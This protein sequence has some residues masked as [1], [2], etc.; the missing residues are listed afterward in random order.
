[1]LALK[2]K[3]KKALSIYTHKNYKI[4]FLYFYLLQ[5]SGLPDNKA[6]SVKLGGISELKKYMKR[7]MPFVQATRENVER[8]GTDALSVGLAFD[9]A[10]ILN[11]N[12]SYLLNTLDVSIYSFAGSSSLRTFKCACIEGID[13]V[14]NIC[15]A[16]I[17]NIPNIQ[18]FIHT[19]SSRKC[20]IV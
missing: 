7:V 13:V 11:D 12:K 6:I 20:P 14:R 10:A 9:E 3:I 8:V 18:Y 16:V 19:R 5:A 2:F 17:L 1:M 15:T 4:Y